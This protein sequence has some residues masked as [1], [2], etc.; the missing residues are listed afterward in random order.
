MRTI[1]VSSKN[2][3]DFVRYCRRYG[4]EHDD[5]FLPDDSFVPTDE[6]PAYLLCAGDDAVGAVGLMCTQQ[7]RDKGKARLMIFHSVEQSPAAYALL[8]AAIRQHTDDLESVYGFL[9]EG[10]VE[11]R[12]CW[13]ALGFSLERYVYWMAY[14]SC[15]VPPVLVP[16][17]YSLTAL[18]QA[19]EAGIRE[20]CDLWA[21]NYGEQVGYRGA[22]PEWI[23]GSFDGGDHVPGGVLL[24]RHGTEPVGTIHVVR[25]LESNSADV[26]M[27]SVNPDHR[28]RGLGHLLLRKAIAVALHNGLSPVYLSVNATNPSAVGL[29]RSVGFVEDAV[30][31]VYT[32][33]VR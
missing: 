33:A 16:E 17:G 19:D 25:D 13:E 23:M 2:V 26:G 5:S 6:C 11:A 20:M 30:Y 7:D 3:A 21:Q 9:P 24:L 4:A 22:P 15:E 32:L 8:L 29:Y 10:K 1:P 27:V 31:V 12:R 28:G 18:T 14:R